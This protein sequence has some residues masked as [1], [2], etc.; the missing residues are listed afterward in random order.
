MTDWHGQGP[1]ALPGPVGSAVRD[2][3]RLLLR[4]GDTLTV[5]TEELTRVLD[6]DI[7][8]TLISAEAIQDKITE[9][10][11]SIDADYAGRELLLVGVLKGACMVMADLAR[12]LTLAGPAR[13]HGGLVVRVRHRAPPAS[14][15][16]SRT[17]TATSPAR[18]SWSSRTSSTRG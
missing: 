9:L 16:S 2:C 11:A 6:D 1:V 8:S 13:L 4:R 10:A 3:G 5:P 12:A 17:S 18:T 14:S 15:A 7:E